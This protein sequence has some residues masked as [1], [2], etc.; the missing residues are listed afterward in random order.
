MG[1]GLRKGDFNDSALPQVSYT[2]WIIITITVIIIIIIII[3]IISSSSS[4][5]STHPMLFGW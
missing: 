3:I 5:S 2:P 1:V 4:S